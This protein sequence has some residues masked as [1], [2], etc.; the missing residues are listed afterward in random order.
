MR[1]HRSLLLLGAIA[2]AAILFSACAKPDYVRG[3]AK[4]SFSEAKSDANAYRKKAAIVLPR[5]AAT[6]FGQEAETRLLQQVIETL[7]D[8]DDLVLMDPISATLPDYLSPAGLFTD[9]KAVFGVCQKARS[10]GWQYL[11]HARVLNISPQKRETGIWWFRKTRYFISVDVGLDIYDTITAAKPWSQVHSDEV[12]V[13]QA[14]YEGVVAG[15]ASNVDEVNDMIAD[16]AQSLGQDAIGAI[17]KSRWMAVVRTVQSNQ[18][19]FTVDH[20]AGVKP[21][22]AW[23][24]FEGHRVLEGPEGEHYVVPGYKV[25]DVRVIAVEQIQVTASGEGSN[26]IRP[27][28][29]AVPS[30]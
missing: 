7:Q 11:L 9:P 17:D 21:G 15:Q 25:A 29:I 12:K 18:I 3:N 14:I 23:M 24:V 22:D 27:G 2:V 13:N 5:A 19:F 28:D 20:S 16:M 4:L 10:D 1:M 26:E 6:P 30:N 8:D